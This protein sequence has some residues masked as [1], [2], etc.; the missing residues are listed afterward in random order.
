MSGTP[1]PDILSVLAKDL[2]WYP[3]AA[4]LFCAALAHQVDPSASTPQDDS[5]CGAG[6]VHLSLQQHV[7]RIDQLV[8]AGIANGDAEAWPQRG[9]RP[10][11]A[12]AQRDKTDLIIGG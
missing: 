7:M 2:A 3:S 8:A 5:L 11:A 1:L 6:A 12:G 9:G 10:G 4:Q